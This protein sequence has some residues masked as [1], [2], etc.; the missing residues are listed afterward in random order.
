[1]YE[2]RPECQLHFFCLNSLTNFNYFLVTG[3]SL[4]AGTSVILA[5]LLKLKYSDVKC[6]AFG[7]PGAL[8]NQSAYNVSKQFVTSIV[9]GDDIVPRCLELIVVAWWLCR[10]DGARQTHRKRELCLTHRKHITRRKISNIGQ[11]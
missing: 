6:Y 2:C 11:Q 1:M 9:V 4:G 5:F 7:P 8:L 3:H 10:F